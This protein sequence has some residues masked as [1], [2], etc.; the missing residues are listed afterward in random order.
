[1]RGLTLLLLL[2]CGVRRGA[3]A[4]SRPH[5]PAHRQ[6]PLLNGRV[7]WLLWFEGWET[8]PWVRRAP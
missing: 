3:P 6:P 8:A 4:D 2:L 1:M 5:R 7:V